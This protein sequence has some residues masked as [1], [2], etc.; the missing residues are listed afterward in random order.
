MRNPKSRAPL[1]ALLCFLL[2]G[3]GLLLAQDQLSDD[4]AEKVRAGLERTIDG[5]RE[6]IAGQIEASGTVLDAD[7]GRPLGNVK[8]VATTGHFDPTK[9]SLRSTETTRQTVEGS[10]R[11]GCENCSDARLRF[12]AEGYHSQV[13]RLHVSDGD[14]RPPV[15]RIPAL[16][17]TME[18]IGEAVVLT[19]HR[20]QL[21][22]GVDPSK[23]EVLPL[24][25]KPIGTTTVEKARQRAQKSGDPLLYIHLRTELDEAGVPRAV[26]HKTNQ[27]FKTA[28]SASLDFSTADGGVVV[29]QPEGRSVEEIR[30]EMRQAPVEGYQPTLELDPNSGETVHFFVR[31]GDVYGRGSAG[32]PVLERTREGHRV[33]V[34]TEIHL[35]P[36]GSR[37]LETVE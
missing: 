21:M 18:A 5:M 32:P 9:T 33:V 6:R 37:N 30:R 16:T 1:A 10:F 25:Q 12:L 7:T 14:G 4:E 17:V 2:T 27:F 19:S 11:Y 8:M 15:L 13:V 22:V 28:S 20:G 36:D 24:T 26:A 31:I 23:V 35:N 34:A 3:A 29:Y